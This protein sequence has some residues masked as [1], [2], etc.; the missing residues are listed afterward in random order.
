MQSITRKG[1]NCR[2]EAEVAIFTTS[3]VTTLFSQNIKSNS[4]FLLV[5]FEKE[6]KYKQLNYY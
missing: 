4:L 2:G 5:C 3:D 1:N 6:K